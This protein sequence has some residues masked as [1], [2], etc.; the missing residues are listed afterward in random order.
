MILCIGFYLSKFI[1][2]ILDLLFVY[3]NEIYI[4]FTLN[5]SVRLASTCVILLASLQL[6][7][8]LIS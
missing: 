1:Y 3:L 5:S 6:C 7:C 8:F 2:G 4:S